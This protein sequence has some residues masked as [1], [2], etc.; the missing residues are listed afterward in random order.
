MLNSQKISIR[1]SEV[2][3]RLNEL[4][5]LEGDAFTDESASGV[6]PAPGRVPGF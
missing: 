4:A 5:G 3:Q 1:L 6:R 2:R